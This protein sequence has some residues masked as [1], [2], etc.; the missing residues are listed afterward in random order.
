[1]YWN[2]SSIRAYLNNWSVLHQAIESGFQIKSNTT[3]GLSFLS[4]SS[5]GSPRLRGIQIPYSSESGMSFYS[6]GSINEW[7]VMFKNT[8]SPFWSHDFTTNPFS[9]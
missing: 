6:T 3:Q 1:M 8:F 2:A 7:P 5:Q 4:L 9:G